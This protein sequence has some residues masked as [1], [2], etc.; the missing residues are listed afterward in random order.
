[1]S[2]G[3]P[4]ALPSLWPIR[5]IRSLELDSVTDTIEPRQTM[6]S[7]DKCANKSPSRSIN[8]SAE[9]NEQEVIA[10]ESERKGVVIQPARD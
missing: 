4:H 1:M 3:S 9:N 5:P 7:C 10:T 6:L 8:L 2:E